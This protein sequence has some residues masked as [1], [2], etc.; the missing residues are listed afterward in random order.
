ML[1][2][3]LIEEWQHSGEGYSPRLKSLQSIGYRHVLYYLRG[4][5]TDQEMLRLFKRDT[6]RFAKRQLT[7]FRR[8][9]RITW[10]DITQRQFSDILNDISATCR[11]FQTRVQL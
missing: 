8:D 1:Q 4:I 9:P 5:V 11:D 2:N 10:Y 3:G 7:W 6:R